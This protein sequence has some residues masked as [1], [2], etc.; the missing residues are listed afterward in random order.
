MAEYFDHLKMHKKDKC[1]SSKTDDIDAKFTCHFC[2]YKTNCQSYLKNH[3][4]SHTQDNRGKIFKFFCHLCEY[5]TDRHS[6]LKRHNMVHTQERPFVCDMCGKAFN[7]KVNLRT[8]MFNIHY[9]L[10]I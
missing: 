9:N 8:H 4:L 7:Q 10:T 1:S 2:D 6:D 3:I 5:K